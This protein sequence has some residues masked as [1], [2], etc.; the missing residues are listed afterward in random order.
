MTDRDRA[1]VLALLNAIGAIVSDQPA[2]AAAAAPAAADVGCQHPSDMTVSA[3]VFGSPDRKFCK[4]CL[5][6]FERAED[7]AA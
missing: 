5:A 3:S 4:V 7:P 1:I 2:A 6:L